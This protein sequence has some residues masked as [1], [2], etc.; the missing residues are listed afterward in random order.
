MKLASHRRGGLTAVLGLLMAGALVLSGCAQGGAADTPDASSGGGDTAA[1]MEAANA[2]VAEYS[3]FDQIFPEIESFTPTVGSVDVI[4]FGMAA[5]S[6]STNAVR[7]TEAFEAAGWDVR[8][9]LD[10][11]FS[12]PITGGYI[13]A[14]VADG[15]DVIA[16]VV[17]NLQDAGQSVANA[18][19]AGVTIVCVMCP[20]FPELVEAGVIFATVDMAVQG[21]IL[22]WYMIQQAEAAGKFM[23]LEDPGSY[24]TVRRADGF[25]R[26]VQENCGTCELMDRLV[27]PSSDIGLPGPP[28][29]S[30]FLSANPPGETPLFVNSMADV[31]GLP[32]VKTLQNIGRDDV[33]IGGFDADAEAIGMIRQGD[34]PFLGT[35]A[36]PFY[37]ADWAVVDLA[38]RKLS[39][40]ELWD[41]SDLPM[42][43]VTLENVKDFEEFTPAGDWQAEFKK[44]WG[45]S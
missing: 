30:A 31:V 1:I 7:T 11:E 25:D 26:I 42:Q 5:E 16:G 38:M 36:L 10:G 20:P 13:D 21:E 15:R 34:T 41:A 39:G 43:L 28:Q 37:W 18:L 45:A 12:G 33:F 24:N 32:M 23:S 4:A 6:V 2:K 27:Q 14:A 17:L 35:V 40:A 3:S 29:W 9:P 8:G 44:A 22:A 19:D